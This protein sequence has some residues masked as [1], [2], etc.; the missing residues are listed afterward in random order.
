MGFSFFLNDPTIQNQNQILSLIEKRTRLVRLSRHIGLYRYYDTF[1]W[2]LY[3]NGLF[4][5]WTD[6]KLILHNYRKNKNVQSQ[7]LDLQE[8][9]DCLP[10]SGKIE[11][12][13]SQIIGIRMLLHIATFQK[14]IRRFRLL[15]PDEKTV[16]HLNIVQNK[17]VL[18]NSVG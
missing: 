2:R 10:P 11:E 5:Y 9:I 1:D 14:N 13:I 15:N 4:L 8:R 3:N 7:P 17:I 12:I 6:N 16:G 18:E